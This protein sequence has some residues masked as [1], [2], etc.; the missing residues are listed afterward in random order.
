ME[1]VFECTLIENEY[2][3]VA[4]NAYYFPA[5][6]F[7]A[8][9]ATGGRCENRS[10]SLIKQSDSAAVRPMLGGEEH[11][12]MHCNNIEE[13]EGSHFSSPQHHLCSNKYC[14]FHWRHLFKLPLPLYAAKLAK[15]VNRCFISLYQCLQIQI[16]TRATDICSS[17]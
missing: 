6:S 7:I 8:S 5:K 16:S 4:N 2:Y 11:K 17:R 10:L 13:Q 12:Q 15:G 9:C 3:T 1:R 14:S